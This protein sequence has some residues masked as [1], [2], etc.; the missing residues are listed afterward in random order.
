MPYLV[1]PP[2]F[3]VWTNMRHRC[4]NPGIKSYHRYGGR[5][6]YVCDEWQNSFAA[7]SEW[8]NTNGYVKGLTLE[9]KDNDGPYSPDNC[10][11]ANRKE[12]SLNRSTS[13]I[14]TAF[15]ETKTATEWIDDPRCKVKGKTLYN[16]IAAGYPPD[17]RCLAASR[18]LN[19]ITAFG[20]TKPIR[21][22]C[23]DPR[24]VAPYK[25]VV[26]RLKHG[27]SPERALTA[28]YHPMQA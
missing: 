28:M 18:P 25:V 21:R 10:K 23:E 4:S 5:G 13:R 16:R 19:E 20:E 8:A 17:E 27:H 1:T 11:W 22:W 24:C 26:T 7:F 14:I 15:G 6:I 3:W 2:L 9:R 12:Q